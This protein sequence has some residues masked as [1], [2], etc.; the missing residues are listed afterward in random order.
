MIELPIIYRDERLIAIDKP[1]GLLVHRTRISED[2]RF[3]LQLLRNQIGQWV[4]PVHRLD[5]P[6]SGVLLFGLDSVAARAMVQIFEARKV[7]K[8]YLAIV[9]GYTREDES[10]D[11]AL[12]EDAGHSV[13]RAV[14]HYRQMATVELP[15][16]VGR[17]TTARYSLLE[18]SPETGRMHQIRKH[19]KHIFHPI[20]GDTT[21]GDGRHNQLFRDQFFVHR[22]LLMA[23][24]L[25]FHHP[26]THEPIGITAEPKGDMARILAELPWVFKVV[27]PT[28]G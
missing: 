19:M 27:E 24:Q 26:F 23:S 18:V 6:T 2:K 21:H 3:V 5:R 22:L 14:T 16:A 10:I 11:Y 13:Q 17:Y 20:V 8:H 28:Q 7:E 1:P 9:R 4:Y 12:Q 15:H 25:R